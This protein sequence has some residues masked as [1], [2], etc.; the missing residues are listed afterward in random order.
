MK[1]R[2]K[3]LAKQMIDTNRFNQSVITIATAAVSAAVLYTV[4][5]PGIV[6]S[7]MFVVILHE[8]GHFFAAKNNT[9][10]A[11]PVLI[12]IPP[13]LIGVTAIIPVEDPYVMMHIYRNGPI[14][15]IFASALIFSFGLMHSIT[16]ITICGLT[17]GLWEIYAI[18]Y[19]SDARKM[20]QQTKG[21]HAYTRA[22]ARINL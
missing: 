8:F 7:L 6:L 20:H 10:A 18:T 17:L 14:Y 15:G 5:P 12:P 21:I 22:R 3:T 19:G 13:F 9:R 2:I 11:T 16:L 1:F 4:F